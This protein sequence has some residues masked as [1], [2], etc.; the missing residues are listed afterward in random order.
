M[1]TAPFGDQLRH[2]RQRRRWSQLDTALAAEIST[3]H[4]SCMETGRAAP[5]REMVLRLSNHLQVP[6]RERN[7]LLV[8]AGYAPAYRE[9]RLDDPA[10]A[11]AHAAVEALLRAH[12]PCPALSLDRHWNVL[13]ANAA[14]HRFLALSGPEALA[15][16]PNA[17]R[18]S[19]HPQGLAPHIRNLPAWRA[20]LFARLDRE[21]AASGDEG[22]AA[23]RAELAAWP[24]P[25]EASAP[26]PGHAVAVPFEIE[27][28]GQALAFLSAT[29]VFGTATDITLAE[30]AL[31]TFLPADAAT[32]AWCEAGRSR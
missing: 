16:Q 2:W 17:L 13:A 21:I 12:E 27:V 7:R 15:P 11:E 29:T 14:A 20:S 8:A 9:H 22:L 30:L 19:L 5:S 10:L 32:R 6:L 23:A 31:E 28:D 3:R 24:A 18:L 25:P 26:A 4:L 1:H